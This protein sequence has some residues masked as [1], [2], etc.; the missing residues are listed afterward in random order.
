MFNS[1]HNHSHTHDKNK[2]VKIKECDSQSKSAI[3]FLFGD[4][5]HNFAD[6][7]TIGAAFSHSKKYN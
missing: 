5:L 7:I 2:T 3:P 6:G 1:G 4:L